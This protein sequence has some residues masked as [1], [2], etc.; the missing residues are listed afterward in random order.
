MTDPQENP[1][2]LGSKPADAP[3]APTG[4]GGATAAAVPMG[5]GS[6][7]D[8]VVLLMIVLAS[9]AAV[10]FVLVRSERKALKDPN[11][12]ALRGEIIGASGDS[13]IAPDRLAKGVAAVVDRSPAGTVLIS[14]RLAPDS[15]S[16]E[17][18]EPST[19]R[20]IFRVSPNLDTTKSDFGQGNDRGFGAHSIDVQAPKLF[21]DTV[22]SRFAYLPK[23]VDYLVY[24]IGG[25]TETPR[26]IG[27]W[28]RDGVSHTF[29]A[30][31]RGGHVISQDA[32]KAELT[33]AQAEAARRQRCLERA[34]SPSDVQQC[35]AKP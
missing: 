13:L 21:V 24:D 9:V 16:I 3:A 25:A 8:G 15:L 26:M 10:A 30:D 33:K 28:K 12:K 11:E 32:Q 2:G 6:I 23:E 34:Q 17:T 4:G 18:R 20:Y 29:Q 5:N 1:F 31:A 35:G 27:F 22:A 19:K 14:I 7:V